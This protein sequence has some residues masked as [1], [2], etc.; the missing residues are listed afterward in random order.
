VLRCRVWVIHRTNGVTVN[1][2]T[3]WLRCELRFA[4]ALWSTAT[5]YTKSTSSRLQRNREREAVNCV[6]FVLPTQ[7]SFGPS[8]FRSQKA[9][10]PIV[11]TTYAIQSTSTD[12]MH[13]NKNSPQKKL[14]HSFVSTAVGLLRTFRLMSSKTKTRRY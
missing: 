11:Y 14:H 6:T 12:Q 13:G 8:G 7:R 3:Y 2:R 4:S 10:K 5:S 1:C 9:K